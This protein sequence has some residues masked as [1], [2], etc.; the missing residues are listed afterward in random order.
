MSRGY[1]TPSL[2]LVM[3]LWDKGYGYFPSGRTFGV[4]DEERAAYLVAAK[5]IY[6]HYVSV[7]GFDMET[8]ALSN[9]TP[10]K[11]LRAYCR[12]FA[13]LWAEMGYSSDDDGV[14]VM[15]VSMNR[16]KNYM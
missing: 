13:Q 9:R 15:K 5:L 2:W 12:E 3:H 10:L 16:L 8:P 11:V 7:W 6:K 14:I 1:R 4:Y